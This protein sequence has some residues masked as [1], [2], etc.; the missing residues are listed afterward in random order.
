MQIKL[1]P[2]DKKMSVTL[3]EASES[4]PEGELTLHDVLERVGEQGVLLL[5]V[6]LAV[7]FMLPVSIPGTSIPFGLGVLLIGTGVALNRIPYLPNWLMRRRFAAARVQAI[8]GYGIRLFERMEKLIHP[9]LLVLTGSL[10]ITRVNGVILGSL[11]LL[12]MAPWPPIIPLSNTIPAWGI[13]IL[14]VGLMQRDG[15]A[16]LLGWLA[17]AATLVYFSLIG[18]VVFR[19]GRGLWDLFWNGAAAS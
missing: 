18:V 11:G 2:A 16:V 4:L 13:M 6:L 1:H 5:C 3:R 7:P 10:A 14:A 9:R 19:A 8:L 15:V 17:W 12:L